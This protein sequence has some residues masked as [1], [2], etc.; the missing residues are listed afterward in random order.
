MT[1]LFCTVVYL[2]TCTIVSLFC[3]LK[4]DLSITILF[5]NKFTRK[6]PHVLFSRHCELKVQTF[7]SKDNSTEK[8]L[9]WIGLQNETPQGIVSIIG[10]WRDPYKCATYTYHSLKE[11]YSSLSIMTNEERK[12]NGFFAE[13]SFIIFRDNLAKKLLK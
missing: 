9:K 6:T 3:I 7:I 4:P 12:C 2:G 8:M 13:F 10:E 5:I 1:N 11:H